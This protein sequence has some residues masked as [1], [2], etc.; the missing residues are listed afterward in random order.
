MRLPAVVPDRE[1]ANETVLRWLIDCKTAFINGFGGNAAESL[2]KYQCKTVELSR[3]LGF[4]FGYDD[5]ERMLLTR[6]HWLLMETVVTSNGPT[7]H[8]LINAE[9][10]DRQRFLEDL[11]QHYTNLQTAWSTVTAPVVVPDTNVYL[12]SNEYFDD[13]DWLKRTGSD[14]VRL[15]V[16]MAVTRELDKAKREGKQVPVSL[17]NQEPVRTRARLTAQKLRKLFDDP[18]KVVTLAPGVEIELIIDPPDHRPIADTD[19]EIIDRTLAVKRLIGRSVSIATNDIGMQF[20]AK[21]AGLDVVVPSDDSSEKKAKADRIELLRLALIYYGGALTQLGR[22]KA[23]QQACLDEVTFGK[24][25]DGRPPPGTRETEFAFESEF[26]FLLV[27]CQQL[28]KALRRLGLAGMKKE[29]AGPIKDLRDWYT[30]FEDPEGSAYHRFTARGDDADPSK[31]VLTADDLHIG[32]D[33]TQLSTLETAL[34]QIGARLPSYE[35]LILSESG[36]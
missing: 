13:I 3:G 12:H 36:T 31:L 10:N 29:L 30:H 7:V 23:A 34:T 35:A 28:D 25:V 32:G 6:R 4:I 8:E 1:H 17:A 11:V 14:A 21:A 20:A 18:T 24:W 16:P 19:S 9:T 15:L 2:E 26:H 27:A 5:I 33:V 22:V